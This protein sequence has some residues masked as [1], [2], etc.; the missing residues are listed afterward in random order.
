M[1]NEMLKNLLSGAIGTMIVFIL[2]S[3]ITAYYRKKDLNF[4]YRSYINV[5]EIYNC[6]YDLMNVDF[7]GRKKI[8]ETDGYKNLKGIKEVKDR[9]VTMTFLR[10]ENLCE[11]M[12]L[13]LKCTINTEYIDNIKTKTNATFLILPAKEDIYIC[14]LEP[15][16]LADKKERTR[17]KVEIIITYRTMSG[18]KIKFTRKVCI[19]NDKSIVDERLYKLILKEKFGKCIYKTNTIPLGW[20]YSEVNK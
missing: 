10:I 4:K 9:L 16:V 17:K 19:D 3:I 2:G 1:E 15:E 18:E 7:G 6:Q 14:S 20:I 11:N 12:I 13:D 5:Y 8:I